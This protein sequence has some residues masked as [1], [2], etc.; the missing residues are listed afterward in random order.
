MG[1]ET[2][3]KKKLFS[4][5]QRGWFCNGGSFTH[6][7]LRSRFCLSGSSRA[8][9]PRTKHNRSGHIS[10]RSPAPPPRG[11]PLP[12]GPFPRRW[13]QLL[14]SATAPRVTDTGFAAAP[15]RWGGSGNMAAA[16]AV[17]EATGAPAPGAPRPA[18]GRASPAGALAGPRRTPGHP[19]ACRLPTRNGAPAPAG[20]RGS[21]PA[22]RLSLL[23]ADGRRAKTGSDALSSP[24]PPLCSLPQ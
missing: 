9:L 5:P 21:S 3:Y 20:V 22:A 18:G 4:A 16:A 2:K 11:A 8:R 7:L 17:T 6:P 1:E 19:L 13:Q 23:R 12:A 14:G 15:R 10:G 24:P